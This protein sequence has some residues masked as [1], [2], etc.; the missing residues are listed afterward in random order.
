MEA[1]D[2]CVIVGGRKSLPQVF[3]ATEAET[4]GYNLRHRFSSGSSSVGTPNCITPPISTSTPHVK[5]TTM[6]SF[7]T[8]GC[9]GSFKPTSYTDAYVPPLSLNNENFTGQYQYSTPGKTDQIIKIDSGYGGF[10]NRY[11]VSSLVLLCS[12]DLF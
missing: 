2:S 12:Q 5:V 10:S 1:N 6:P 3:I 9:Y 11:I 8:P 7:G 4:G